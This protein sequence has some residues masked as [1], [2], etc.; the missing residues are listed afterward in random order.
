MNKSKLNSLCRKFG[1]EIHGVSFM[2]SL[3][4]A[5]KKNELE[6]LKQIYGLKELLIYDVGANSGIMIDKYLSIFPNISIHAFEPYD[7]YVQK[8]NKKYE[9]NEKIIINNYAL[10]DIEDSKIFNIN[11]SVDTSSFLTSKKTGLNSDE[12]VKTINQILVHQTTIDKYATKNNHNKIHILKLDIQGSELNALKGAEI[13]LKENKIDFIFSETYFVEQYE[14]QPSFFDISNYLLSF[15]YV[16]QDLYYPIY[17]KGKIAWCDTLF[18][19][20]GLKL[21]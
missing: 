3:S 18:V 8:L 13:M 16:M 15:G 4:S 5:H 7:D 1:F 17:G 9:K 6:F 21:F 2:Q 11:K 10:S 12:A 20:G 14:N 19:R